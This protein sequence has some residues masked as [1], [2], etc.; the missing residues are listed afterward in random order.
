MVILRST[1]NDECPDSGIP[2]RFDGYDTG[3]ARA[4]DLDH[5]VNPNKKAPLS[6]ERGFL[7]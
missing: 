2:D 6:Y 1:S 3:Q 7:F 5:P 4:A